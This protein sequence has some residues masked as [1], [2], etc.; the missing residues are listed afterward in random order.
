MTQ[1]TK[2]TEP[3]EIDK[4]VADKLRQWTQEGRG[5]KLWENHEIGSSY[6]QHVW[7]PATDTNGQEYGKPDWR[8]FEAKDIPPLVE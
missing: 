8:Y 4:T 2:T 7:T 3:L 5:F 1:L 6:A